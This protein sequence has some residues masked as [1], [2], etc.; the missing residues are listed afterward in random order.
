MYFEIYDTETRNVL[1]DVGTVAEALAVVRATVGKYGSQAVATWLLV[2]D[3]D[4]DVEGGRPIAAGE[5]LTRL[6]MQPRATA[7]RSHD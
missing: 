3:G 5:A 7:V 6:A 2:E 1:V 4:A